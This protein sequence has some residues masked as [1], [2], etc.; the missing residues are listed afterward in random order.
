M[1]EKQTSTQ[2]I[3]F[4][5]CSFGQNEQQNA[6]CQLPRGPG[7][8]L[9]CGCIKNFLA[10]CS[11]KRGTDTGVPPTAGLLGHKRDCKHAGTVHTSACI[12]QDDT[13]QAPNNALLTE[14]QI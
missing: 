6:G 7:S 8:L 14:W 3:F 2:A 11:R 5:A 1:Q 12:T 9:P 13:Q 4:C 10:V